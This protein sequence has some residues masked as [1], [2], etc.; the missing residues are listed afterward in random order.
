MGYYQRRSGIGGIITVSRK[1]PAF[2]MGSV[3]KASP[4]AYRV[5]Y[6]DNMIEDIKK[7]IESRGDNYDKEID[8]SKN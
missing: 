8:I 1:A 3:N 5:T 6:D 4:V 2:S 7:F